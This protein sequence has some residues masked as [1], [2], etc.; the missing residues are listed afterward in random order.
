MRTRSRRISYSLPSDVLAS[1]LSF[2]EGG[3]VASL[4]ESAAEFSVAAEAALDGFGDSQ[5]NT[6]KSLLLLGRRPLRVT[7]S[8]DLEAALAA[9]RDGDT[10]LVSEDAGLKSCETICITAER[11]RIV[12]ARRPKWKFG[13]RKQRPPQGSLGRDVRKWRAVTIHSGTVDTP[14]LHVVGPAASVTF[15]D[16]S[17]VGSSRDFFFAPDW[18]TEDDE[19]G[20]FSMDAHDT[21]VQASGGAQVKIKNCAFTRFGRG[22]VWAE[23][24]ANMVV[25]DAYVS[26]GYFGAVANGASTSVLLQNCRL[27]G[28]H[29]YAAL[30][31]EGG[32]LEIV[33]CRLADEYTE[34]RMAGACACGEGSV[35]KVDRKTSFNRKEWS[36]A[37]FLVAIQNG[38]LLIQCSHLERLVS[39]IHEDDWL[40]HPDVDFGPG[41]GYGDDGNDWMVLPPADHWATIRSEGFGLG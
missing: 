34:C 25:Q 35:L 22:S 17:F 10:I 5:G 11:L 6:V 19:E 21:G 39:G 33:S 38:T 13:S 16:L 15:Q 40:D 3:V 12:G 32:R 18:M 14:A 30:A 1:I 36:D 27:L 28:D 9:A 41:G 26:R 7:E 31:E 4:T 29:V 37:S 20:E 2:C 24:G 8:F 23:S